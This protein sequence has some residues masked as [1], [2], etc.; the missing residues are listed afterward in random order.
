MTVR[1]RFHAVMD[2]KPFDRLP[3]LEWAGW[4][5]KTIDRWHGEGL[6]AELTDC[7]E[8]SKYLEM[9]VYRQDW[10]PVQTET[11]PQ[12]ASHGAG[13]IRDE[14]DYEE[15]KEY[16]FPD[17]AVD[18]AKWAKWAKVQEAGRE[19]L[20]FTVDGFFW[21]PRKLFGIERHLYAFYDQ[22]ELM[23]RINNDLSEWIIKMTD[24]LCNVCIP[25]FMTFGEDMSYNHGP[26]PVSYTHLTLPTILRV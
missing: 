19:V 6:P 22:P 17:N 18:D 7:Y 11:C 23:H 4:W 26:M 14:K 8:I 24:S 1:E 12:P 5:S 20:W 2:F 16:L 25:D 15:I 3:V 10:L 13:L 21:F 9:D